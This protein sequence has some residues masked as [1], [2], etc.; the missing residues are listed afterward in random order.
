MAGDFR[1]RDEG[2]RHHLK[3]LRPRRVSEANRAARVGGRPTQDA[4]QAPAARE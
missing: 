1:R 4:N 3:R 2:A